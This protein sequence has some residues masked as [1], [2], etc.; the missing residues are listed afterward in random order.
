MRPNDPGGLT[1]KVVVESDEDLE[2]GEGLVAG[3]DPAQGVRHGAGGIGDDE[4]VSGVGFR[5]SGVQVGDAAHRQSGQV[6]DLVAAYAGHG[7]RQGAD[8][9]G[10]VDDHQHRSV[11]G[12][13][14][15]DRPQLR[16]VVRQRLVV[17]LLSGG[18]Q[19]DGVVLTFADVDAAVHRIVRVHSGVVPCV[20]VGRSPIRH[21]RP[22]P[23][24]QRD[25]PNFGW[26]CPY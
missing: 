17:D 11:A 13:A 26:P 25:L 24:L 15:E 22:A 12:Q 7:D 8:R 16:F 1:G 6:A 10:L 14:V 4:R 3:I 5:L 19:S 9:I 2:L 21:R 18:G 20:S 23:T